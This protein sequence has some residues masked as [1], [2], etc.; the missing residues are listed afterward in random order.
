M[1]YR[2]NHPFNLSEPIQTGTKVLIVG[3]AP[4]PR[5]SNPNCSEV[6][7]NP[8]DFKFFYGSGTN[9]FW[10]WMNIIA[11]KIGTPLPSDS[12]LPGDYYLEARSFLKRNRLW[13]KDVLQSYQRR[14]GAEC[15]PL[16]SDI[17]E[18]EIEDLTDFRRVLDDYN[19]IETIAFTSELAAKW[20]FATFREPNPENQYF[21]TLA[22]R[23]KGGISM[24]GFDQSPECSQIAAYYV[25]PIIRAQISGRMIQF[26]QLPTPSSSGREKGRTDACMSEV[27]R[28]VL[29]S[30]K[31]TSA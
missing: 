14:S 13:M 27:Y 26:F 21:E 16:D 29:F 2:E 31:A 10:K 18:P 20:T 4:P 5:F 6:G 7:K 1:T 24:P 12:A 3:T 25:P 19:S 15:S 22:S 30:P 11:A 9:N 28:H 8:L 23:K 17:E